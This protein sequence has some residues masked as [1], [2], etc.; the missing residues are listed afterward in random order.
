MEAQSILP[1]G[2]KRFS[3]LFCLTKRVSWWVFVKKITAGIGRCCRDGTAET[4]K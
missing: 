1:S 4:I 3:G 2:E